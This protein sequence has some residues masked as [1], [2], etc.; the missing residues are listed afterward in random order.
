MKFLGFIIMCFIGINAVTQELQPTEINSG[1]NDIISDNYIYSHSV[2]GLAVHTLYDDNYLT[3][4]FQQPY[5]LYMEKPVFFKKSSLKL[6]AFPNPSTDVVYFSVIDEI[7]P[8][9]CYIKIYDN[10]GNAVK[11]PVQFYEFTNGQNITL[12]MR[13]FAI[14]TYIVQFISKEN[15]HVIAQIKIVKL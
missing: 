8:V 3:Q 13:K 10:N 11:A 7:E 15:S 9:L 2:G 12:N 14:G 1:G 4:G 5:N 6:K